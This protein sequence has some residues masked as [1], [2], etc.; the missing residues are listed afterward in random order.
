VAVVWYV[1][2]GLHSCS[3]SM[4][5]NAV[6][7]R[8]TPL[9]RLSLLDLFPLELDI[10]VLLLL[11]SREVAAVPVCVASGDAETKG[12]AQVDEEALSE[13][14]GDGGDGHCSEQ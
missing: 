1:N 13:F 10:K 9:R 11:E 12:A 7:Y 2:A 14:A 5:L 8:V 6:F 3:G 4:L